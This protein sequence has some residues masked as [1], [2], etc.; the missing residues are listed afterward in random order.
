MTAHALSLAAGVSNNSVSHFEANCRLPRLSTLECLANA[1]HISPGW[2]AFG[3][4]AVW[5]PVDGLRCE[6]LAARLRAVRAAKGLTLRELDRRAEISTGASRA[7]E[8]GGMP[9]LDTIEFLARALGVSPA[10]LAYGEGPMEAPTRR[11]R[12]TQVEQ[13]QTDEQ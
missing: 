6:G 8:V 3:M 1:L 9:T 2:I 10:W 11:Q 5:E 7:V 13:A 12:A 4:G